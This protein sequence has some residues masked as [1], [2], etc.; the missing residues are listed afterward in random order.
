[1]AKK[2]TAYRA[3]T[4]SGTNFISAIVD[5]FQRWLDFDGYSSRPQYWWATL[6]LFLATLVTS[7][8]PVIG[9]LVSVALI[10]PQLSMTVRRLHDM[11]QTGKWMWGYLLIVP[12]VIAQAIAM[13]HGGSAYAFSSGL[14]GLLVAAWALVIFIFTLMPTKTSGNKFRK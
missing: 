2:S 1:M 5:M 10:V 11:G 8:I 12:Y 4:S 14:F 3:A 7:W 13:A 6:F 9:V